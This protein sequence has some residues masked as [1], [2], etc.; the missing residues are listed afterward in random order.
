MRPPRLYPLFIAIFFFLILLFSTGCS[1]QDPDTSNSETD[2]LSVPIQGYNYR[3]PLRNSPGIIDPAYTQNQNGVYIAKQI[4]DGL[5]R[6][7]SSLTIHPALAETWQI[8]EA[9]RVYRFILKDNAKFHNLEKVTSDDVIFSLSRLIKADPPPAVLPHLLKIEGAKEYRNKEADVVSG[10]TIETDQ[11][12]TVRLK[13]PHVPFLTAL[14]MYQAAILSKKEVLRLGND[15]GRKPVGTG[16][17][18]IISLNEGEMIRLER[19]NDYFAGPA[20][21]DEIHFKIYPGGQDSAVLEDF[22]N[23]LLEEM[24]VYG[25]VKEALKTDKGLQWFQ[26]PSLSLFFYGMNVT[27]PNLTDPALRSALSRAIDRH[28][29]VQQV[30]NGQF[31]IAR[32][33]LPPGMPGYSPDNRMPDFQSD[34]LPDF[35]GNTPEIEI[36]SAMNTPRVELEMELIKQFWSKIGVIMTVKYIT[37]WKAFEDYIQSDKVQIYRY[38][39][40]ADMPDPD[41]FLHSLFASDASANFMK[42]NDPDVDRMLENARGIVD[43]VE[44]ADMVRKAEAGIM[45]LTPL[46]PLFHMNV[47]R[48]YQ[49]Y[50]RSAAVNAL[51]VYTMSLNKIWMDKPPDIKE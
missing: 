4:F 36:V 16:P 10:L 13:S 24:E 23:K 44:R 19:F 45:K 22:Q 29:F 9:G 41:S 1:D 2:S 47:N 32:T 5:V 38:V 20:F 48:V 50:V 14:G 8:K 42:F 31:D 18:K 28:S 6:F 39:W 30:Y 49:P 27:H 15:F 3:V 40:F 11:I 17:F 12:F 7:D 51:G 43:P 37:D 35:S 46:I 25:E 34:N 21:L 33:I 26:R